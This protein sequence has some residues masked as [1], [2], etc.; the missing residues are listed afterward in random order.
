MD[1]IKTKH[2]IWYG[3]LQRM[4][5]EKLLKQVLHWSPN[6]RKNRGRHRKGYE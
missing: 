3:H 1:D 6:G 2:Q 5:E 4:L